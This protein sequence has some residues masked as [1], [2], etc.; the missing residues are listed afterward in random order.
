MNKTQKIKSDNYSIFISDNIFNDINTF[1]QRPEYS[2]SKFFILVDK[3]VVKYCLPQLI[4]HVDCLKK[5]TII[6]IEDGKNNKT[7]DTSKYLWQ[8]LTDMYADRKSVVINLGGGMISDIGGFVA[9]TFKRGIGFINIPTTLLSQVDASTGGKVGIDFKGLKNQIGLFKNPDA[10]FIN[11]DFLKTI[12][13]RCLLSGFAEIVKYSL[14]ADKYFWNIIKNSPFDN[15]KDWKNL[16]IRS[17]ELKNNIVI[18]DPKEHNLRKILNFGHTVGHAFESYSLLNDK[19]PLLHGEAVA[20]GIICE[21]YLSYK[22][23]ALTKNELNEIVYFMLS[24]FKFYPIKQSSFN[25]LFDIMLNDKKNSKREINFTLIS[26]IGKALTNQKCDK[27]LIL[28][29]LDY[30][31]KL[32]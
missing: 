5:A 12:N 26:C 9:S 31:K 16:I 27:K 19:R 2:D 10:V 32:K 14:I 29:G 30:Y 13:K 6:E 1:L 23:A 21:S 18:S 15:I 22:Y 28:Q 24:N 25:D 4:T 17:V 7:I 3:N 20:M 11:T 8:K